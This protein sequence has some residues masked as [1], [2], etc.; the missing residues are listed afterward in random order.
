MSRTHRDVEPNPAH[1]ACHAPPHGVSADSL[2]RV[3]H[4]RPLS[5]NPPVDRAG[6]ADADRAG[7]E[8]DPRPPAGARPGVPA[9]TVSRSPGRYGHGALDRARRPG[10]DNPRPGPGASPTPRFRT[11][12][13]CRSHRRCLGCRSWCGAPE[14]RPAGVPRRSCFRPDQMTRMAGPMS[15]TRLSGVA[16]ASPTA[17]GGGGAGIAVATNVGRGR[18]CGRLCRLCRLCPRRSIGSR[19]RTLPRSSRC[20]VGC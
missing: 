8:D 10:A 4:R 16:G 12:R 14:R 9:E 20:W 3:E 6:P 2:P 1:W 11:R 5:G 15:G 18:R 7:L 17:R 19:R 13:W